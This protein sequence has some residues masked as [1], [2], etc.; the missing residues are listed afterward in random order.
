MLEP[1]D[2]DEIIDEPPVGENVV[3]ATGVLAAALA[4]PPGEYAP[5]ES[6]ALEGLY[7]G[8]FGL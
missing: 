5:F 3:V 8:D 7:A 6:A 2:N 1:G 4:A